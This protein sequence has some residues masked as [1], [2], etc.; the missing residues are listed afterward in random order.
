[1]VEE[2]AGRAGPTRCAIGKPRR[3]EDAATKK[4]CCELEKREREEKAARL[5]Q[6]R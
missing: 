6:R 4:L 3:E 2:N 1:L 5:Q